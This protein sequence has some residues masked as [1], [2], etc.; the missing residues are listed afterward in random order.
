[1]HVV[2]IHSSLPYPE[3][4]QLLHSM[5]LLIPAFQGEGY[6]TDSA[7][8]SIPAAII[9]HIPS[10]VTRMHM[11]AYSYLDSRSVVIRPS[12]IS[13][14]A[15]VGLLRKNG[16]T[17]SNVNRGDNKN[18][19]LP[20]SWPRSDEGM[21]GYRDSIYKQNYQTLSDAIWGNPHDWRLR[22]AYNS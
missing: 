1:L 15:A 2:Q 21:E 11:N 8:S 20:W 5:D 6:Y 14:M 19:F 22:N 7:S 3:F 17:L 13:T 16:S 9:G 4:Y 12:S 10:L 18:D